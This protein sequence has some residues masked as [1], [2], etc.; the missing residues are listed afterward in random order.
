MKKIKTKGLPHGVKPVASPERGWADLGVQTGHVRLNPKKQH[1]RKEFID[2]KE[3]QYQG[4]AIRSRVH[5]PSE[6]DSDP[7]KRAVG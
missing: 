5:A 2:L 1:G 3:D 7:H 4:P 6:R